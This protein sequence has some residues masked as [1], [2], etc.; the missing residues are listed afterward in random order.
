MAKLTPFLP[1]SND[2]AKAFPG[3]K[4]LKVTVEQDPRG[5]YLREGERKQDYT[6][7]TIAPRARCAN[8]RCQNGGANL[9][10]IVLFKGGGVH[11]APCKGVELSPDRRTRTPCDN[12]FKVTV[13]IERQV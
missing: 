2:P 13:A 12:V 8:P 6:K 3:I 9:Q 7:A 5:F 1:N 10:E 4:T 11:E